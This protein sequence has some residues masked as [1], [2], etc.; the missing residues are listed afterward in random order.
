M[1]ALHLVAKSFMARRRIS[2]RANNWRLRNYLAH[3]QRRLWATFISRKI[4]KLH[5]K[6]ALKI[7]R[8]GLDTGDIIRRF[9]R[10][11]QI[12]AA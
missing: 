10:E 7:V 1:P 4:S 9:Q 2:R 6:V 8:R 12:L 5:R 3:R 11:E